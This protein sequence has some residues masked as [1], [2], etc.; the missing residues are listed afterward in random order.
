MKMKKS[1]SESIDR[2]GEIAKSLTASTVNSL[3][4]RNQ[5]EARHADALAAADAYKAG[6][7]QE[8]PEVGT[9][10]EQDLQETPVVPVRKATPEAGSLKG[11][12]LDPCGSCGYMAKSG[13]KCPR[14]EQAHGILEAVPYWRR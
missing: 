8:Q 14:C 12:L 1:L 5:V 11:E 9:N 3:A 7:A 13:S 2:L 10:R 6:I 4:K